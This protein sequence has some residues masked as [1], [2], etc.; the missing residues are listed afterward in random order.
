V[1]RCE[2]SGEALSAPLRDCAAESALCNDGQCR[3]AVTLELAGESAWLAAG[4]VAGI[5]ANHYVMTTDRLLQ[6]IAFEMGVTNARTLRWVVYEG[7]GLSGL[8]KVHENTTLTPAP[9]VRYMG[10]GPIAVPL[11]SG[12]SYLIG[13]H[14]DVPLSSP[15]F[16]AVLYGVRGLPPPTFASVAAARTYEVALPPQTLNATLVTTADAWKQRLHLSPLP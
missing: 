12:R 8:T 13:V 6:E 4:N 15:G 7:N 11:R 5:R 3:Q 10:S 9:G 1:V 2:A 14:I 16:T